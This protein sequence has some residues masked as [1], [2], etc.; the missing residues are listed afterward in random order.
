MTV[1]KPLTT[2][3]FSNNIHSSQGLQTMYNHR[4]P[5][6]HDNAHNA[7]EA[8]SSNAHNAPE[9]ISSDSGMIRTYDPPT[10]DVSYNTHSDNNAYI[11]SLQFDS[12]NST[13]ARDGTPLA[14]V[15]NL[16]TSDKIEVFYIDPDNRLQG[17]ILHLNGSITDDENLKQLKYPDIHRDSQLAAVTYPSD[18]MVS[19]GQHR[20]REQP[21]LPNT[22]AG[23]YQV[24]RVESRECRDECE[25]RN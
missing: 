16:E 3:I 14:A 9:T 19:A 11:C 15:G 12:Y 5:S 6:D 13:G 22:N 1:G 2:Y 25:A 7:L 18:A 17:K 8:M 21:K 10:G 23:I 4:L 24:W 20:N